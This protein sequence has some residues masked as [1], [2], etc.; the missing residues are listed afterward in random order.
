MIHST[1]EKIVIPKQIRGF[2]FVLI[3]GDG[4]QPFEKGWQKKIHRID[5][6][7]FVRHIEEGKNYGVQSNESFISINGEQKFLIVIDFDK[8][9]F[10]DK[11]IDRFPKTFTTTSGSP[12]NCFH[13]WFASDN[14]KAFKI[15]DEDKNTLSDIIGSGNQIIAPGSKHSSGSI[16]HVVND[17]PI[18]FISY[19]EIEA[20]LTPYDKTPKKM[21]KPKKTYAPKGTD[22]SVT[23]KMIN[24]LSMSEI[25]NELGIDTNKNPTNCFSHSSNGGKC[26]SW[27]E[28]TAHCFHCDGSWNKFSLIRESKNFTDKQTF[29]WFA[30]KTGLVD[31]LKKS[32]E[33]YK[34]EQK[35][36]KNTGDSSSEASEI[37]SRIGQA[38]AFFEKQPGYF[39]P[40]GLW[41]FWNYN[42][43]CY[44]IKDEI[45][46]LN[47]IRKA[48]PL[49]ADTIDAKERGE[50]LAS[51]KQIGRE[52]KPEIKPKGW[53]QFKDVLVNPKTGEKTNAS[54]KYL[55]MNPIPHKLGKTEDTP[56]INRLFRE[57]VV[58]EGIQDES[59]TTTLV[60]ASSYA[61][62]DDL[63]M[64][65]LFPLTGAGCNGKGTF[66]EFIQRLVGK[67]NCVSVDL[68]KL[69]TNNFAM[70]SIYKKLLAVT[71]E[72]S[73]D[74]LKNTNAI[75]KLTGEDL[76][77]FEFKGKT[78]FTDTSITTF[79][80]P[81][82]SLPT[83]PDKSIGF[84]RRNLI[85][86]FPNTF[87]I[88]NDILSCIS[89]Q[90][91]ENFCLKC[92]NTL[93]GLYETNKFTNE[94]NYEEREKKYEERSN[95]LPNF[96]EENCMDEPGANIKLQEFGSRFN[97]W[98]KTRRLRPLTI[99]QIGGILRENGYELGKRK[100]GEESFVALIN[101]KFKHTTTETTRTTSI[102]SCFLRKES[103]ATLGSSGSSGSSED[104]PI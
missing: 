100:K 19:S 58:K 33:E 85:I 82:N 18:A 79:F 73:H 36:N 54:P 29:D 46:L 25:L 2:N 76:I 91:Y 34:K 52:R 38:K 63:F 94:G 87:E 39:S 56:E 51:L 28:E 84:Y 57:W 42:R 102:S 22:T 53:I 21:E 10:Q 27:N 92:V 88:K 68:K 8:R 101:L 3:G 83:T 37:F 97:D 60:E 90:E 93:R 59:Y 47:S 23:E 32:R 70:S 41:L 81:G 77:E 31:E 96:I 65:R 80:L 43:Y 67:E 55:L 35:I 9:E 45:D 44:E 61:L 30:E 17:L 20:I 89:E 62:T 6:S 16:Y 86:D 40:E 71:G 64:Q 69:S 50:I 75:K 4:K 48:L 7:S 11:V 103:T 99:R 104:D 98:L 95:P 74:D 5:D 72:L 13:L 15:K 1:E 66:L 78:S 14:N 24:S 26:F 49:Q 12:K